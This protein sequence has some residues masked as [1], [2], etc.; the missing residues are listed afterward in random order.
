MILNPLRIQATNL[1]ICNSAQFKE[2]FSYRGE[3]LTKVQAYQTR[4]TNLPAEIVSTA[5]L[6]Q[7]LLIPPE[8]PGLVF[9]TSMTAALIR[10]V[11]SLLDPLQKKDKSLPL[12]VLATTAG[13][14]TVF[15]EVRHWGTHENSLPSAE[16]L[17]DMGIRALE[18][19][20][21][22]YWN[23]KDERVNL[24]SQWASGAISDAMTVATFQMEPEQCFEKLVVKLT[25]TDDFEQSSR[26]WL[27]LVKLLSEG[28]TTFPDDF[29]HYIVETMSSIPSCS[30]FPFQAKLDPLP[31]ES[32]SK[33]RYPRTLIAWTMHILDLQGRSESSGATYADAAKLCLHYPNTLL[34][35][36]KS[37]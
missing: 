17:R 19:L 21:R 23:K 13:L 24:I 5:L 3:K 27:P 6:T 36:Q 8:A 20:W 37:H 12:T 34:Y 9:R 28:I 4:S 10:F 26:I 2:Y 18:W 25:A 32:S 30:R 7:A 29:T 35:V 31:T 16:V 14:P 22:N 11:N 1:S 33:L 15:V